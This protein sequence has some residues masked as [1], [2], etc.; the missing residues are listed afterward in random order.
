MVEKIRD[1]K[2]IIEKHQLSGEKVF[3]TLKTPKGKTPTLWK[4]EINNKILDYHSLIFYHPISREGINQDERS[5]E[6]LNF[7]DDKISI[8]NKP[9]K[10]FAEELLTLI[11]DN[12]LKFD[13]IIP[14]PKS[15]ANKIANGHK[16]LCSIISK[17]LDIINGS[18]VLKRSESIRKSA[19]SGNKR[20]S[21]EEQYNSITCTKQVF[22]KRILL[23]DDILT[24]GNTAGASIIKIYENNPN[25]IILITLGRTV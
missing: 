9:A 25:E 16:K 19:R 10:K 6:I 23:F 20:P 17:E 4:L 15:S 11:Y 24:R 5:K 21:L 12:N 1:F 22:N 18:G 7:K 8:F 13:M 14:I 3:I 2:R